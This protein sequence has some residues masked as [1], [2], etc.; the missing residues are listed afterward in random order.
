[1]KYSIQNIE[2]VL[3]VKGWTSVLVFEFDK[4]GEKRFLARNVFWRDMFKRIQKFF[5]VF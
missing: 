2:V 5:G 1:V 3:G 4:N